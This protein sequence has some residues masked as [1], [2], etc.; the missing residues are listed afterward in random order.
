MIDLFCQ[1]H[2]VCQGLL[3]AT[4]TIV[5]KNK[6]PKQFHLPIEPV[7]IMNIVVFEDAGVEQLFP[8]TT[9]R[10][11]YSITCATYQLIDWLS[12]FKGHHVGLVRPYLAKI[13]DLDF[14]IF[15]EQVDPAFQ[16]TLVING[17]LVP[18][19]SNMEKVQQLVGK[20][21]D[22]PRAVRCGWAIGAAVIPTSQ[23]V[24]KEDLLLAIEEYC[25]GAIEK[26]EMVDI[27]LTLFHYPHDV[28]REN[29]E[30]FQINLSHRINNGDYQ[31]VA[32]NVFVGADA[33]V[34]DFVVTQ[35]D[36]GPIVIDERAMIGP[37]CFLRGPVYIGPKSRVNEH[38]AIKDFASLSHTV[39]VGGEIEG[40]IIEA[41]SNKQHHGFLGHSYLGSWI[42]LGAGTCN[43]DLKNTYGHVKMEYRDEKVA[44]LMQF[45]GCV[46]G[47][48]SK[49]AINTGIFTGKTIG[50]C[51]MLYGF[52]TTNV[53]SFVNYARSFGQTTEMPPSV[54]VATQ[55][56]MFGRRKV[57]QR[58]CDV[59]LIHDM[60]LATASERQLTESPLSL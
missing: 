33:H 43:S 24:G 47:D 27:G 21:G 53:P 7:A 19:L 49:S 8:I 40:S 34:A 48:Y 1:R 12:A 32:D 41:Y 2:V 51:S 20:T 45:V 50:A 4:A 31:E 3:I 30:G 55:K 38:A 14:P 42:N 52:V 10:A 28:I 58:P 39:K 9:G 6:V 25:N 57:E 15:N 35:S 22:G 23:L 59:Q 56:R 44:T 36:T 37:F 18:S 11:A 29:M 17:R 16:W 54:M 5:D 60:Y 13:Q 46:M 26:V